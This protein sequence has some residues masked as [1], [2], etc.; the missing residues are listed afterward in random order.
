MKR[1]GY[2]AGWALLGEGGF[3]DEGSTNRSCHCAKKGRG[4]NG[5]LSQCPPSTGAAGRGRKTS[6]LVSVPSSCQ[7]QAVTPHTSPMLE[8]FPLSIL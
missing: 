8:G 7:S 6:W 4:L 2:R 5:G 3:S 1:G